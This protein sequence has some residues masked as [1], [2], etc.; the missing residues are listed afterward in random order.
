MTTLTIPEYVVDEEP[1][2]ESLPSDFIE[3]HGFNAH[4]IKIEEVNHLAQHAFHFYRKHFIGMMMD[5][6]YEVLIHYVFS[7]LDRLLPDRHKHLANFRIDKKWHFGEL[8]WKV[9]L[10]T[11]NKLVVS[12]NN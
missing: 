8:S 10:N 5:R 7:E 9:I 2:L 11:D 4:H 1:T 6:E 3:S 12:F